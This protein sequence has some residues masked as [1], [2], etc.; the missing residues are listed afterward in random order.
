[1]LSNTSRLSACYICFANI[2][3]K[4][5]FTVVDVTH[6]S[7]DRRSLDKFCIINLRIYYILEFV[8]RALVGFEFQ[9][10]VVVYC[11]KFCFFKTNHIVDC[12]KF[13]HIK[14][15]FY[16]FCSRLT[17][18]FAENFNWHAFAVEHG[19]IYFDILKSVEIFLRLLDLDIS[20]GIA[21][22]FKSRIVSIASL[23]KVSFCHSFLLVFA[24][25][26]LDVFFLFIIRLIGYGN[27]SD[28]FHSALGRKWSC[29]ALSG[30]SLLSAGSVFVKLR[31]VV[32]FVTST[33]HIWIYISLRLLSLFL[34][35]SNRRGFFINGFRF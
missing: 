14:Q 26:C 17:N 1:M 27:R 9:R 6:N 12:G 7:Y 34:R 16:Y 29:A 18:F 5:S 15:F 20:C 19:V 25:S 4:R 24:K 31:T 3:Q 2:V 23:Q 11:N 35:S 13:A 28:N 10:Y 32:V 21:V 22:V 30:G 8:F 33:H